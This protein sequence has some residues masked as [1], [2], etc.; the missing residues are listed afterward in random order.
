MTLPVT[1]D[2]EDKPL[3]PA[4]SEQFRIS[5]GLDET[6]ETLAAWVEFAADILADGFWNTFG[7][8]QSASG[9]SR[10]EVHIGEDSYHTTGL[11]EAL[12]VPFVQNRE[13]NFLVRSR[14]P[15]FGTEIKVHVRRD[16]LSV[17]PEPPVMSFGVAEDIVA[18]EY[19]DVPADIAYHRFNQ[20]TNA[21]PDERAYEVWANHTD[22]VVTMALPIA[23][24]LVLATSVTNEWNEL[25][26]S[27]ASDRN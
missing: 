14:S 26:D 25:D 19:F 5:F 23:D 6:P 17:N 4:V 13:P 9:T 27:V 10:H 20:Y 15:I 1:A 8:Q 21:F 12:I 22:G 16:S 11:F 3:D 24:A 18:P 2:L 7:Q